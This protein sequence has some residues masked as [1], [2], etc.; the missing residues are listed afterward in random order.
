M[1]FRLFKK[2]A[3]DQRN[4][5]VVAVIECILNQNARDPGAAAY[6][7]MNFEVI[8]L[9]MKYHVGMV[10]IP[11]PEIACLGFLRKK[12]PG[13][14]IRE[15]LDTESGRKCCKMLAR[16]VAD[17][18]E[19]YIDNGNRVLAVLGGNPESPGCAVHYKTGNSDN[20]ISEKSGIFMQALS[21]RSPPGDTLAALK[22]P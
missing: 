4:N 21:R 22:H 10:Q 6:P 12:K 5:R 1:I 14:S 8:G 19:M 16:S 9:C 18:V 13:Q 11:C 7:A 17:R 20:G 15:V 3:Q 2:K